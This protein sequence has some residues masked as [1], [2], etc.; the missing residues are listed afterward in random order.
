MSDSHDRATAHLPRLMY[1][2]LDEFGIDYMLAY[3]SWSLGMLDTRD[4]ELRAPM[5]RAVNR[6]IA[7]QF[8]PYADRLTSAALIPMA[9]PEEAVAEL[10]YAVQDLGFKSVVIA[11]HAIRKL[12]DDPKRSGVPARHVRHRQRLRLRP[13]LGGVRRARGQSGDAQQPAG[14]PRDPLDRPTTSSTTSAAWP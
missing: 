7:R 8:T 13:V 2:R 5:L 1:E 3:P 9:T 12:T 11:G 10:R 6:Y 14:A 4:D